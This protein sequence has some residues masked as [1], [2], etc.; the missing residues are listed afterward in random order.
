MQPTKQ[1]GLAL[2]N[3][4]TADSIEGKDLQHLLHPSTNLKQHSEL[5]PKVHERAEGV[6]IWDNQGTPRLGSRSS[7][8]TLLVLP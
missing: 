6:Y 2:H 4:F 5:G 7:N 1:S 3:E 8:G